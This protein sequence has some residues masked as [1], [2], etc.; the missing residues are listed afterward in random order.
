MSAE[1]DDVLRSLATDA[2]RAAGCAPD[3]RNRLVVGNHV[4]PGLLYR[5]PTVQIGHKD[6]VWTLHRRGG[7]WVA[8]HD[9]TI[10]DESL[11]EVLKALI[12]RL[13]MTEP[14]KPCSACGAG[15]GE[16]CDATCPGDEKVCPHCE[17]PLW[18][19][20]RWCGEDL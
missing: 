17:G 20:C 12:A 7:R 2:A 10:S 8:A 16:L 14:L 19:R 1:V 6:V 3:G 11:M 9:D 4:R 13:A 5:W 15:R 18:A